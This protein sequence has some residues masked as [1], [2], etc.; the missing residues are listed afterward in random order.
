MLDA[1]TSSHTP[2]HQGK[3]RVNQL[4]KILVVVGKPSDEV[5]RMFALGR[6]KGVGVPINEYPEPMFV[7]GIQPNLPFTHN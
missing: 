7:S 2:H 3:D 1:T 5:L 6:G 4:D